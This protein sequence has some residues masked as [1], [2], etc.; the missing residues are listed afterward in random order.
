MQSRH[1]QVWVQAFYKGQYLIIRLLMQPFCE[2]V[3]FLK[4]RT[5][6]Y[7]LRFRLF[8]NIDIW[9]SRNGQALARLGIVMLLWYRSYSITP[10]SVH[11]TPGW[12]LKWLS[13]QAFIWICWDSGIK[14]WV[15]KQ[16]KEYFLKVLNSDILKFITLSVM[17][18]VLAKS[19]NVKTFN[20]I[21]KPLS[22]ADSKKRQG[23]KLLNSTITVSIYKVPSITF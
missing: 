13:F 20:F 16:T 2:V 5:L 17:K 4:I 15:W 1:T 7:L 14:T 18:Q 8:L 12:L 6:H 19:F 9:I 22:E 23:T 11:W 3:L 10:G 21:K